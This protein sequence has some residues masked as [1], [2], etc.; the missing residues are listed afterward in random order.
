MLGQRGK[1]RREEPPSC[2]GQPGARGAAV[3]PVLMLTRVLCIQGVD[4]NEDVQDGSSSWLRWAWKGAR[5][6]EPGPPGG[7]R[8][9][10]GCP[11]DG[12][13]DT[14]RS[15]CSWTQHEASRGML[16]ATQQD[17]A[18]AKVILLSF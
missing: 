14:G 4:A 15:H 17:K 5:K 18:F 7:L 11:G 16:S 1:R 6:G 3:P 8:G 10:C 9:D 13:G 12:T 2:P